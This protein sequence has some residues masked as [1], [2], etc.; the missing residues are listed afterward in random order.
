MRTLQRTADLFPWFAAAH[1]LYI[2]FY[3]S[4]AFALQPND[5]AQKSFTFSPLDEEQMECV[6]QATGFTTTGNSA[7]IDS[8]YLIQAN[9][10]TAYP[11]QPA[12]E[13]K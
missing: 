8:D 9:G 2:V 5:A 13:D 7:L 6:V 12:H 11:I 4:S 1:L 10:N 3:Y